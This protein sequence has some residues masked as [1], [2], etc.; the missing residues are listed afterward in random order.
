MQE[1]ASNFRERVLGDR[2]VLQKQLQEALENNRALTQTV[3]VMKAEG[4][5][6][7]SVVIRESNDKD[8][9]MAAVGALKAEAE[10]RIKQVKWNKRGLWQSNK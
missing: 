9:A 4:Q 5:K 2:D 3:E 6:L 10:Q 7:E 1:E 8:A